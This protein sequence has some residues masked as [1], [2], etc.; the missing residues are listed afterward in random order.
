M[1]I[2]V[3][4]SS[5][6]DKIRIRLITEWLEAGSMG[7]PTLNAFHIFRKICLVFRQVFSSAC[8]N[9]LQ[10]RLYSNQDVK[11]GG[12]NYFNQLRLIIM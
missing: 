8:A 2:I 7:A 10:V 11:R 5:G 9:C 1:Y 12:K 4:S 6:V 3:V